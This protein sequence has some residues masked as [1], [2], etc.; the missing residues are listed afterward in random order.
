[1]SPSVEQGRL[2]GR[3][4]VVTGGGRG[5]GASY[6][7]SMAS[8][9]AKVVINDLG[10]GLH[11]ESGTQSVAEVVAD[12]IRAAGGQAVADQHDVAD[13]DGAKALIDF[14]ISEYGEL[15]VLINNAGILRDRMLTNMT[16]DEWDSVIRVHL[17]GHFCAT[18]HAAVHWRSRSKEHGPQDA[19]LINITS[20][21][22]LHGT[23]GQF[24][25]GAAKS[26]VATMTWLAH[27]ELNERYG[28]RSYAVAPSG[29][30]RMSLG[31]PAAV[32]VVAAPTDGRFDY[33]AAENVADVVTW[34]ANP[35][36]SAPSGAVFGVEGDTVR[37]YDPWRITRTV[38]NG[39]RWTFEA[40][41]NRVAELA[42]GF[43]EVTTT[44]DV[45]V[46][47]AEQHAAALH[48]GV[49]A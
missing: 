13:F 31:S 2:D 12:E 32:D 8:Q 41:E 22:G 27:L 42:D 25:Y 44:S 6:A 38:H 45:V 34:L 15:D 33:W 10:G 35:S 5:L 47:M 39:E 3:V 28:V 30:T 9:G 23:P 14:A 4:V 48:A 36:C 24:N 18:K 19:A 37:R 1:M 11:G 29:R 49:L 7:K 20:I 46:S 17:R 40:L 26:A 43:D 16:I 21:A